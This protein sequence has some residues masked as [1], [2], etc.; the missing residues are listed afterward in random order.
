MPDAGTVPGIYHATPSLLVNGR[1]QPSLAE[2]LQSLVVDETSEGLSRCEM[3]LMNWGPRNGTNTFQFFDGQVLDFGKVL[4]VALGSGAGAGTV[5]EGRITGIEG[6]YL[7]ERPPEVLVLAEDRLQDLRMRRRTRTFENITDADLF[8]RVASDH[9][10]QPDVDV[11]GPTHKTLAQ[12]NQSDLAF[13]RERARAVDAEIWVEGT[14]L[15]AKTRARRSAGDV[16]LTYQQGLKEMTVLADL[17]GQSTGF[18]ISGWD[19]SSKDA[20]SYRATDAALGAEL[21]GFKSGASILESSFGKRD[22]QAS[23]HLPVAANEA[24]AMAESGFRRFAR[25]FVTGHGV[26]EG[27]ARI[28]PGTK[29]ELKGL[30]SPFE[31]K[32]YVNRIRHTFEMVSGTHTSFWVE[33]PGIGMG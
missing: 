17:A 12:L 7:R 15:K 24:Q 3:T 25:R 29:I 31:G 33:R 28:R 23:H 19:V 2:L 6:R 27:D 13:L 4:A 30:G 5:F 8:R 1:E 20:I 22:Q 11:T 16:T 21:N 18:V 26:A 10:L 9:G 32:Y 14:T